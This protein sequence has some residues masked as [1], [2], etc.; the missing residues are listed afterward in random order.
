MEEPLLLDN[1]PAHPPGHQ[2]V[3]S[4]VYLP[5]NTTSKIQPMDGGIIAAFKTQYR[6]RLLWEILVTRDT[7]YVTFLT[8][9]TLKYDFSLQPTLG[10]VF[11]QEVSKTFGTRR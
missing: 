8:S 1:C 5:K 6:K 3:T 4:V 9:F 10:P 11:I 7:N 2:L